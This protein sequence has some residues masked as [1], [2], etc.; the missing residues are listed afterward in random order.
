MQSATSYRSLVTRHQLD[1]KPHQA[2]CVEWC[3]RQE[4]CLPTQ[5]TEVPRTPIREPRLPGMTPRPESSVWGGLPTG[6][7]E[8]VVARG[9]NPEHGGLIADEMGLGKTIQIIALVHANPLPTTLI[10]VPVA[11][12]AQWHEALTKFA[13]SDGSQTIIYYHGPSRKKHTPPPPAPS[14]SYAFH[15]REN[16]SIIALTTYGEIAR[17]KSRHD[18][19]PASPIHSQSW[20]RVVFDEAHHLRTPNTNVHRAALQLSSKIKWLLTGTPIQNSR[21]DFFALCSVIGVPPHLYKG[22]TLDIKTLAAH[23]LIKRTKQQLKIPMP[24][25]KEHTIQVQWTDPHESKLAAKLHTRLGMGQSTAASPAASSPT[26]P[27]RIR[28]PQFSVK[29]VEYLRARQ[30]CIHPG[31]LRTPFNDALRQDSEMTTDHDNSDQEEIKATTEFL[32]NAT[33]ASSKLN[34]ILDHIQQT[35]TQTQTETEPLTTRKLV[36]CEFRKEMDYLETALT[37]RGILTGRIDGSTQKELKEAIIAS[38]Y[39]QVLLLQIRTCSEGLNLQQYSDVYI[40]TPQWNP[41]LESQAICRSYRI[42]QQATIVNVFRF[43]MDHSGIGLQD[44]METLVIKRQQDKQA[45]N[46]LLE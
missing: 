3:L 11:L 41:T 22:S 23:Y 10:V 42:G 30:L 36:F 27:K 1:Y 8:L 38:P 25:L 39:I 5:G 31:L 13:P 40:V 16:H 24:E 28:V 12:L 44:N 26:A 18:K 17:P 46:V 37:R 43:V 29:L 6:N 33:N 21:R 2:E 15:P 14:S 35:R 45:D 7:P 34:T 9:R 19:T 4:G 20:S 32:E